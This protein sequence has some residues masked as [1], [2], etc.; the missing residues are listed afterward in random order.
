M[1]IEN[2]KICTRQEGDVTYGIEIADLWVAIRKRYRDLLLCH[3]AMEDNTKEIAHDCDAIVKGGE[4]IRTAFHVGAAGSSEHI[5]VPDGWSAVWIQDGSKAG[6]IGELIPG[7]KPLWELWADG[8]NLG[9]AVVIE[10]GTPRYSYN[11]FRIEGDRVDLKNWKGYDIYHAHKP[12]MKVKAMVN[13][14]LQEVS[15]YPV[16][17]HFGIPYT[18]KDATG[19][20]LPTNSTLPWDMVFTNSG[21]SPLTFYIAFGNTINWDDDSGLPCWIDGSKDRAKIVAV[22]GKVTIPIDINDRVLAIAVRSDQNGYGAS[23]G[24]DEKILIRD[25]EHPDY[26]EYS[27]VTSERSDMLKDFYNLFKNAEDNTLKGGVHLF[28]QC[29]KA[30]G[31]LALDNVVDEKEINLVGDINPGT[32]TFRLMLATENV[33]NY[34]VREGTSNSHNAIIANSDKV[35]GFGF[36]FTLSRRMGTGLEK[37]PVTGNTKILT[38]F[39]VH[40]EEEGNWYCKQVVK[41][42]Y[43]PCSNS[44]LADDQLAGTRFAQAE[45]YTEGITDLTNALWVDGTFVGQDYANSTLRAVVLNTDIFGEQTAN[46]LTQNSAIELSLY[47]ASANKVGYQLEGT[48]QPNTD[49]SFFVNTN[50]TRPYIFFQKPNSVVDI[51]GDFVVYLQRYEILDGM[52]DIKAPI[53]YRVTM[54]DA[55]TGNVYTADVTGE[56]AEFFSDNGGYVSLAKVRTETFGIFPDGTPQYGQDFIVMNIHR[57]NASPCDIYRIKVELL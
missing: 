15:E 55:D 31:E 26:G 43:L 13:G 21:A 16:E 34:F 22:G 8:A 47:D 32:N 20:R 53:G 38:A 27:W 30:T 11:I 52:P 10:N 12:S 41:R 9:K 7:C 40:F 24:E 35:G 48:L 3:M 42:A 19:Y 23:T 29:N 54:T 49:G 2:G 6:D 4:A 1:S 25:G 50:K 44:P 14:I 45:R 36:Y 18:C 46:N 33:N 51:N 5:P 17:W 37:Y 57:S 28:M 39:N 56:G